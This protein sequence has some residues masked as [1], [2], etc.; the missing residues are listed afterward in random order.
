MHI[1]IMF[2]MRMLEGPR[3]LKSW[4]RTPELK[5]GT[6]WAPGKHVLDQ[7]WVRNRSP[8]LACF[9]VGDL[10]LLHAKKKVGGLSGQICL[11]NIALQSAS[12]NFFISKMGPIRPTL[13]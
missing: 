10:G 11:E 5:E 12:L 13:I 3:P 8:R 9:E 7:L 6:H 2:H 1:Q 4:F